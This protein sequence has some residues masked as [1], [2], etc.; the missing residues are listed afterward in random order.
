MRR[1]RLNVYKSAS[2]SPFSVGAPQQSA[3]ESAPQ[4][5]TAPPI[6]QQFAAPSRP[7][8]SAEACMLQ[9]S[10]SIYIAQQFQ[11]SEKWRN[12]LHLHVCDASLQ[13][14]FSKNCARDDDALETAQ[15]CGRCSPC[16][17]FR[18]FLRISCFSPHILTFPSDSRSA[19]FSPPSYRDLARFRSRF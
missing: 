16:E 3:A 15:S 14:A 5:S 2:S 11:D 1:S 7:Q 19:P 17:T 13:H 6:A 4:Q 8:Q 9:Q 12:I 18:Q 10:A